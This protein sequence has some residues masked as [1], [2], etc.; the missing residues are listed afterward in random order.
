MSKT[1][2]LYSKYYDLLY[3]DKDYKGEANYLA[4]IILEH[5]NGAKS[6]LE[7][8]S[9]TGIHGMI[10]KEMG[11]DVFGIEQS[12]SMTKKAIQNGYPCKVGD[13]TDFKLERKFDVVFSLF[14]VVSYITDN[15]KLHAVFKNAFDHLNEGG[16]F[17]FDTWYGPA[18]HNLKPETRMK[19]V[20]NDE[21]DV[22][23]IAQSD[24][25]ENRNVVDVNYT[26]FIKDKKSNQTKEINEKHPMRYFT[27]PEIDNMARFCGFELVKTEEFLSK[28]PAS[29]E[30]WGVNFILKK[31]NK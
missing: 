11:F 21:I 7:L 9:G 18:V 28:V 30:T 24:F 25:H 2:S 23:R 31:I 10:F 6:I 27:I 16:I 22:A 29:K 20:S 13:I 5:A 1:F 8:G 26:I 15:E 3:K 12:E 14:H 17:V 19:R 4:D